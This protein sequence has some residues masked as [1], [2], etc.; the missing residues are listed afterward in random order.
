MRLTRS[1]ILI[2]V[3]V[4]VVTGC[5][6]HKTQPGTKAPEPEIPVICHQV[7]YNGETLAIISKWYTGNPK[8]WREIVAVNDGLDPDRIF[9]D[10]VIRIPKRLAVKTEPFTLRD[11]REMQ[12]KSVRPESAAQPLE[13]APEGFDMAPYPGPEE[14]PTPAAEARKEPA[15]EPAKKVSVAHAAPITPDPAS[16][17]DEDRR[18][19]L[20][21]KTRYELLHDMVAE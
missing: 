16:S 12:H 19:E 21:E 17:L 14:T 2:V 11:L 7:R 5:S 18:K 4:L 13:P 1:F 3:L 15:K 10:Q 9:L 6:S 8:N 20:Q